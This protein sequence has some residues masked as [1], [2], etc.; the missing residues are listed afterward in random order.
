MPYLTIF[1]RSSILSSAG[2]GSVGDPPAQSSHIIAD[3]S[4]KA[5]IF[6]VKSP[7]N[8]T[9]SFPLPPLV[10]CCSAEYGPRPENKETMK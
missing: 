6:F 2:T 4:A 10:V 3:I 9:P 1:M 5:N 7:K 8:R